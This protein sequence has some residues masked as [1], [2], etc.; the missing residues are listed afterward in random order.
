LQWC[1]EVKSIKVA[2][3]EQSKEILNTRT[4]IENKSKF[5]LELN[6]TFSIASGTKT[7]SF[8]WKNAKGTQT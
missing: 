7:T 5:S 1:I 3:S 4:D 2:T 8:F 6:L